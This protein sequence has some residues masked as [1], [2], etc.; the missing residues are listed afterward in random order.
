MCPAA[1]YRQSCHDIG[2]FSLVLFGRH[3]VLLTIPGLAR[4]NPVAADDYVP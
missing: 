3:L 2:R 1:E 4:L